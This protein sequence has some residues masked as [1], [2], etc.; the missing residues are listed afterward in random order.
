M[1][2]DIY[3]GVF[4]ADLLVGA[5]PSGEMGLPTMFKTQAVPNRLVPFDKCMGAKDTDCWV[6]FF[7]HDC[8]FE[9]LWKNPWRYLPIL[10]RYNGVIAPDF[11]V[12]WELPLYVQVQSIG[13]SRQVASWLRQCGLD[14]I[15]CVRWGREETYPYA[16][17]GIESGDTVAVGTAG[18][19]REREPRQ[20]FERGF[21]PM[22]EAVRPARVVVYGSARSGVFH[23]AEESGVEVMAF[24]SDTTRAFE[25][26]SA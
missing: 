16:F 22:I 1:D 26:R 25:R 3:R 6:H 17:G 12:F 20:V 2:F 24:Q 10:A 7:L 15:P 14:V 13:R 21:A 11:S 5:V 8:R 9:R 19:M 4:N 18:C 23:E